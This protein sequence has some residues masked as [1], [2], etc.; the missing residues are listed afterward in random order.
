Q[1][2]RQTRATRGSTP[3]PRSYRWGVTYGFRPMAADRKLIEAMRAGLQAVGDP[4]R[5]PG[6]EAYMK[7]AMPF[8]GT[9]A[10]PMRTVAKDVAKTHALSSR[11]AWRDT[12]LALWREA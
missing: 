9:M 1:R 4:A 8:L 5:A 12:C 7:S 2:R 11:R 3:Q 10:G 6:A